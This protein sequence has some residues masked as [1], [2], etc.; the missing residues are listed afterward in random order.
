MVKKFYKRLKNF[1][2]LTACPCDIDMTDIHNSITAPS[3][4]FLCNNKFY[5]SIWKKNEFLQSFLGVH[6]LSFQKSEKSADEI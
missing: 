3:N 5:Y 4:L 1:T 6:E 2:N